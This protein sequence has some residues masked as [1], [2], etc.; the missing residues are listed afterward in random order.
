ML[1]LLLF[2]LTPAFANECL[3]H[4]NQHI[5]N[6]GTQLYL[7]ECSTSIATTKIVKT[8]VTILVLM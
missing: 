1:L 5:Y 8:K 6:N 7:A 4:I 2:Y 3:N